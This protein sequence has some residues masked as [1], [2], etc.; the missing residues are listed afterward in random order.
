MEIKKLKL[1]YTKGE[2]LGFFLI[3]I[4]FFFIN[5]FFEYQSF[6]DLKSKKFNFI[7][8]N[9]INQY[10]KINKR[11]KSYNV[12]KLKSVDGYS[13]YTTNHEDI[14]DLKGRDI[15][16]GLITDKISFL[17]F[18]RG[19]YAPSFE[20]DLL[21]YKNSFKN[22]LKE[23][24]GSQH[25]NHE[26]SKLY[27]ALFLATPI[28]KELREKISNFGISHLVAISG[29]HL[30]FLYAILFFIFGIIYQ[31]FQSRYFPYRNKDIDL[32]I[33]IMSILFL[34]AYMLGFTPSVLRSI[35]MMAF[36]FFLYLRYVDVFSF[37]VLSIVVLF[38]FSFKPALLFSVGFWFSVSGIF[39]IYL[40]LHYYSY[41]NKW[42]LLLL[43]NIWVFFM[44]IPIVHFIFAKW[45]LYQLL[46]PI[47]SILFLIFYPLELFLHIFGF[48]GIFDDWLYQLLSKDIDISYFKTPIWFLIF[49]IALS[50]LA[51]F[52][53]RFLYLLILS[54]LAYLSFY[55]L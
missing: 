16:I 36:A 52:K 2:Y 23:F 43:I 51:I 28:S 1:F 46:S 54:N 24:I 18:L 13:F 5:L 41:I 12:L 32:G 29:F 47:L 45:T 22:R 4:S 17:D 40:F 38:L 34:Y 9:V 30:G 42:V 14:K 15:S 10:K 44:M 33:F 7:R 50:I 37:E 8:A 49:Y 27:K 31:Y 11:G 6:H 3:I 48:G 53:E 55:L 25:T 26:L 35:T 39:Y 19:F 20:I 21:E